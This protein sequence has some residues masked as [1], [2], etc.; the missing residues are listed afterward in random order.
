M[1]TGCAKVWEGL[2]NMGGHRLAFK[3]EKTEDMG[4]NMAT[5]STFYWLYNEKDEMIDNGK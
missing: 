1:H 3:C 2:Y 5:D 4:N